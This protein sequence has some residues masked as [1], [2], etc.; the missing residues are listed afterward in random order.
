MNLIQKEN[1][2]TL[3]AKNRTAF[4]FNRRG[5]SFDENITQENQEFLNQVFIDKFAD[6]QS[7][8]KEAPWKRNEFDPNG[9]YVMLKKKLL[10]F[11][12]KIK[13]YE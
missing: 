4:W 7:P 11:C 12:L 13:T 10:N 8:L 6:K 3:S 5:G 2:R 9:M 1:Y